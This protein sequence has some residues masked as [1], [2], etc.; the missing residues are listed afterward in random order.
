M[1][2]LRK[3][4]AVAAAA[5]KNADNNFGQIKCRIEILA[6]CRV[7]TKAQFSHLAKED[8]IENELIKVVEYTT[9]ER[10]SFYAINMAYD[11]L[12]IIEEYVAGGRP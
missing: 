10:N 9:T 3:E 1:T 11:V 4:I 8:V 2:K 7:L 12:N 5:I 6:R